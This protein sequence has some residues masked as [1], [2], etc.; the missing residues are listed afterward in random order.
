MTPGLRNLLLTIAL[1]V[2]AAGGG[3][4]LCARYVVTHQAKGPSL[5]DMVHKSLDLTPDQSR[6]LEAIEKTYAVER[7]RLED[8][9]RAANRELATSIRKGEKDSPELNAA[10]DHLHMAMGALQ[11]ATI[12]HVFDMRAVLT[13]Q[14]AKTFDAEITS[15]L[16]EEGR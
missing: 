13:P 9:V 6:R 16:T 15:A 4:W 14:Q 2:V 5:H 8:E 12:G 7:A 1:V 11:K 10:I 3:A